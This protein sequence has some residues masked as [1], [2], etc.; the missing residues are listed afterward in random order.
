MV[1]PWQESGANSRS[2]LAF[3]F[4]VAVITPIAFHL[5]SKSR[6]TRFLGDLSYPLYIVHFPV[7]LWAANQQIA[8]FLAQR[9]CPRRRW[10]PHRGS[11][12]VHRVAVA[13]GAEP[14]PDGDAARAR[15][16]G[17]GEGPVEAKVILARENP[18][19]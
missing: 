11:H 12:A 8:E 10:A 16:G 18:L 3:Y 15:Q 7:L 5:T 14:Q 17:R 1:V 6:M 13:D 9:P 2:S 4:A 19:T